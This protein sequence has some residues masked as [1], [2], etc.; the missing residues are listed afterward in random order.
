MQF[1]RFL[2]YIFTIAES[3]LQTVHDTFSLKYTW[4]FYSSLLHAYTYSRTS[5]PVQKSYSQDVRIWGPVN[6]KRG[7]S[8]FFST[9]KPSLWPLY[10]QFQP[11]QPWYTLFNVSVSV[12]YP[13]YFLFVILLLRFFKIIF[14]TSIPIGDAGK[15]GAP[16]HYAA[17]QERSCFSTLGSFSSS[18]SSRSPVNSMRSEILLLWCVPTKN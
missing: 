7:I 13:R 2:P 14:T 6:E 12:Y 18:P 8:S 17:F 16:F 1:D 4:S 15:T 10:K 9:S 3:Y 5:I 11:E